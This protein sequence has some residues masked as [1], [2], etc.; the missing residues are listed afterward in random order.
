[1]AFARE[2]CLALLF[3]VSGATQGGLGGNTSRGGAGGS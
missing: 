1:M 3:G 2:A